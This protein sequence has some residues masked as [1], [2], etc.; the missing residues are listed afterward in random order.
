MFQ[1]SQLRKQVRKP[2]RKFVTLLFVC[3]LLLGLPALASAQ[4]GDR[5]PA[6]TPIDLDLEIELHLLVASGTAADAGRL[7]ASLEPVA[8]QLRQVLPFSNYRLGATFLSR[9]KN[10]RPLSVK[11]IGRSLMVTPLL[12]GSVNPT[13]Y[14]ISAGTV[15][16]KGEGS[17]RDIVQLTPFRFGLRI[18]LQMGQ[19][20]TGESSSVI[21][22]PV[23]ITTDVTMRAGEP[24][25]VGTLDAGRPNETLVLVLIARRASP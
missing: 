6:Q 24:V 14:E 13:F 7:P 1:S 17:G 15:T 5:P 18:P 23:G 25:V 2:T 3:G 8:R 4:A 9:V 22:E 19:A 20:K 16:L 10:G 11:G 21:Y 12:E